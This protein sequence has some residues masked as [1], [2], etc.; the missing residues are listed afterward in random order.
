MQQLEQL[1]TQERSEI[2][3]LLTATQQKQFDRNVAALT[4]R[5]H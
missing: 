1:R 5:K 4:P 2:R 3:E